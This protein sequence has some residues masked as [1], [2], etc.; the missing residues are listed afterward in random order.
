MRTTTAQVALVILLLGVAIGATL[1]VHGCSSAAFPGAA[2]RASEAA[3]DVPQAQRTVTTWKRS[4]ITPNTSHLKVGDKEE[5][6]LRGM[7]ANVRIDGFRARVTLDCYFYNDRNRILEG[8]FQLRL[9]DGASPHFLAYGA[10]VFRS[11]DVP[12]D[13][14][15]FFTDDQ[16]RGMTGEPSAVMADR[17]ETWTKPKEAR[18]VPKE[19]AAFA[20]GETVHRRV[21]P[22]LMEWAGAGVF[23]ARVFPLFPKRLHRIVIGYDVDLT[24][25]GEDLEYRLDL[26]EK[27]SN[28]AADV[29]VPNI[30]GVDVAVSPAAKP[31]RTA[32]R[33][34]YRF[35]NTQART[36]TVRVRQPG[37]IALTGKDGSGGEYFA[38]RFRPALPPGENVARPSRKVFLVDTSLSSNPDR[39]NIYLKLLAAL[40]ENNRDSIDRLSVLFF[41][42]ES[43]WWRGGNVENTPANVRALL[44][45]A[46]NLALEGATDLESAL[47]AAAQPPGAADAAEPIDV[48]LLSDAAA[49]WG[50]SNLHAMAKTLGEAT[51]FAYRTGLAGTDSRA[52]DFLTSATGGAVFSIVGEAEIPKAA[53]AHRSRPWS[54]RAVEVPGGGNLM[55]AGRPRVIY[56]G[57]DLVLVGRGTPQPNAKIVLDLRRRDG[58]KQLVAT[59]LD[60]TLQSPL[61]AR[62]Y[63]QIAVTQLEELETAT[64]EISKA[65]ATHFRVTGRTCSL[66]MLESE[67]DYRRFNIKPEED[68]FVVKSRP[69]DEAVA[70]AL[71]DLGD[72]L[73]DPKASFLAWLRKL[74]HMPGMTFRLPASLRMAIESMPGESFVVS[75]APL[76]CKARTWEAVPAKLRKQLA[77]GKLDYDVL[78]EDAARRLTRFGPADAIKTVSSL[79]EKS[80]GDS[81]LARDVGFSAM[82]WGLPAH[83]YHLFRRVADARPY[84]PQTYLAMARCLEEMGRADL[85]MAYFEVGLSGSWAGRFGEFRR[86]VGLEYVR[87]LRRVSRGQL[88]TTVPQYAA[89]RLTSVTGEFDVGKADLVVVILW[90]TDRTD[91]DL[92]VTEPTGEECF[93]KNPK[94]RLGARLT[95]DVTDGYGPEMYVLPKARG[96][97]YRIRAKYYSTD[98]NRLSARTKVYA[99]VYSGWGTENE[100]TS[101]KVV[102]LAAREKMHDIAVVDML[103]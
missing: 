80:P 47:S 34:Y 93:Y 31:T 29:S 71:R 89:A 98:R 67:A 81:V 49:T 21:D 92:H 64:E 75:S 5:L 63:G 68:A 50:E 6:P 11:P 8:T 53:V 85:A 54:M 52:L 73:G 44:A 87:F 90:N 38:A 69:A 42:V 3:A 9:P 56:P 12:Q 18:V 70:K 41:N 58:R 86:I 25:A 37:A 40:L 82:Q 17:Q 97:Q 77:S 24:P 66:L 23:N 100:K 39:F 36:I 83:A 102:T 13:Q 79:V 72:A 76:R 103:Q 59:R 26:P 35:E 46:N 78:T 7:Q 84:E 65:Y 19:K 60:H 55:L 28:L 45:F 22:A 91:I 33:S 32:S 95:R 51:L 1:W 61:A 27:V 2:N 43:S 74:Q 99:T 101:R 16:A 30:P 88:Q 15:V 20:Y 4:R 57:Q 62:V 48:F 96:G 14:P 94:T 10:T